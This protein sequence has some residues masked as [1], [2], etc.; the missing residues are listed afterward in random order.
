LRT[1]AATPALGRDAMIS[2]PRDKQLLK[3]V[4]DYITGGR[5]SFRSAAFEPRFGSCKFHRGFYMYF[6]L[7]NHGLFM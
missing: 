6:N 5:S 1:G 2:W 3:T 4:N 7:L